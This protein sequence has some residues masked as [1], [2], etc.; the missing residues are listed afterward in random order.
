MTSKPALLIAI[1]GLPATGK[2]TLADTLAQNFTDMAKETHRINSDTERKTL[3][4][5]ENNQACD[6]YKKLPVEAY[7]AE[8]RTKSYTQLFTA[9]ASAIQTNDVVIIDASFT[10]EDQRT[11]LADLAKKQGSLFAGIWLNATT[12]TMM[13]RAD[14]RAQSTEKSISDADG[15]IVKLQLKSDLGVI[16]WPQIDANKC[17]QTV[18]FHAL[19]AISNALAL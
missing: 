7:S 2:T 11:E 6:L 9:V 1:G 19:N 17:T 12:E 4:A 13:N 3:W 5:K 14:A 18:H 16:S 10:S 15:A 8:F